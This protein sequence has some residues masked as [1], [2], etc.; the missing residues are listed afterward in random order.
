MALLGDEYA[1]SDEEAPAIAT[2]VVAAP[3]VSLDVWSHSAKTIDG[4]GTNSMQ[5]PM[6]LQVM[7]AKP[8]DTA[9]TH[10]VPYADLAR[11]SQGPANPYTSANPLKRK[12]ALTGDAEETSISDATFTAQHRTFQSLG[13]TRDPT[14]HGAF[15]GDLAKAQASGGKDIIQ[16]RYSKEK[17]ADFRNKRQKKGD[18]SIVDGEGAYMG[19]WAPYKDEVHIYKEHPASGEEELA[20]DEEYVEEAIVPARS[21]T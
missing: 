6:Q 4:H 1:S 5:D 17:S 7:L 2:T 11:P 16:A 21:T 20:S 12:N 3:D 13:Y 14:V 10:N 18:A 19:P 15:V 8:T 9:L